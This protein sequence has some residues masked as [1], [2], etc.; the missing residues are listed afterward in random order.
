MSGGRGAIEQALREAWAGRRPLLAASLA[1]LGWLW[2]VGSAVDRALF[3]T[4]LRAR[5]R[6]A[7]PVLS[8]GNLVVG[9]AGKTPATLELAR[10][11]QAHGRRVAVLSR[12]YGRS[13]GSRVVIVSDGQAVRATP[14]EGGDEPLWLAR[15]LPGLMVVVAAKRAEAAQH[16]IELGADVLLLD[17]GL[18]HRALVRD[19]DL[20]VV[21]AKTGLGN[22]RMLP[23]GPLRE[24]AS[25]ARDAALVWLSRCGSE[26]GPVPKLLEKRP[27]VRTR[28]V[29]SGLVDLEL[30]AAGGLRDLHGARVLGVCGIARPES[31]E[32]TLRELGANARSCLSFADH[33]RFTAADVERLSKEAARDRVDV[34][35]TTEKDALRLAQVAP[36]GF[37]RAIR[38]ET[39]V[40]GD[41]SG[42]DALIRRFVPHAA[43]SAA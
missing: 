29:A 16:A 41:P 30:H 22:G 38:M 15:R 2:S 24:P 34:I 7:V 43:G 8:V 4:G 3:A 9:G 10:R 35:V 5:T 20:V 31:F 28:Y 27:V 6:V 18:S 36:P 21:D 12:G 33:H 32:R 39:E 42:L 23:A 37:A 40:I 1:P 13:S 17:D 25:S 14:D 26:T 11:L 19:A